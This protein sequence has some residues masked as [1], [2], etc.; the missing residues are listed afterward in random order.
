MIAII[1]SE[2]IL[3]NMELNKIL[4]IYEQNQKQVS[5]SW[6]IICK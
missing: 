6:K 3:V 1:L 5:V 4:L 2:I